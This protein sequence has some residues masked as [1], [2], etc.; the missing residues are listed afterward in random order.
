MPPSKCLCR[1]VSVEMLRSRCLCLFRNASVEMPLS[2]RP[3][4][5]CSTMASGHLQYDGLRGSWPPG[6][7]STSVEQMAS[8]ADGLPGRWP[9]LRSRVKLPPGATGTPIET[10][11]SARP[12]GPTGR[13]PAPHGT[14]EALRLGNVIEVYLAVPRAAAQPPPGLVSYRTY[15]GLRYRAV[16]SSPRD[17]RTKLCLCRDASVEMPL[18]RCLCRD[19]PCRSGFLVNAD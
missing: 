19:A 1:D 6:T 11:S 5:T 8:G 3:S 4:S 7:C 16:S 17:W 13:G 9:P 18:S 2:R 14:G 15:L 12:R 10:L